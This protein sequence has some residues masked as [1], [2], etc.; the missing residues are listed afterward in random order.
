MIL[1]TLLNR[2]NNKMKKPILDYSGAEVVGVSESNKVVLRKQNPRYS[3]LNEKEPRFLEEEIA[4]SELEK[5]RLDLEEEVDRMSALQGKTPEVYFLKHN[6]AHLSRIVNE[7]YRAK[8]E[9]HNR[10]RGEYRRELTLP[11]DFVSRRRLKNDLRM[12]KE[13]VGQ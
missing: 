8:Q 2:H 5:L 11:V 12:M 10:G 3:P 4:I 9:A 1:Q 6:Q 13:Y 7:A